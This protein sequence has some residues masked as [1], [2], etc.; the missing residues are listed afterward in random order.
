[1]KHFTKQLLGVSGV[2][3]LLVLGASPGAFAQK[4]VVVDR[5]AIT[6]LE[7]LST[8]QNLT[9]SLSEAPPSGET[10]RVNSSG[11]GS[12]TSLVLG[13]DDASFSS[14]LLTFNSDNWN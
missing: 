1:M 11:H 2:L 10:I 12:N 14:G 4:K 8:G 9:V 3:L 5:E 7:G 6:V 13:S